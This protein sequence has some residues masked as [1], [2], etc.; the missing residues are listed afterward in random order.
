ME[1][2]LRNRLTLGP[3]L[4]AAVIGILFLDHY[5]E[6]WTTS[7]QLPNGLRG[8][9][10]TVMLML[11]VPLAVRELAI[12]FAAKHAK[13]YRVITSFGCGLLLLHAFLMQFPF[14]E[15]YSTPSLALIIVGGMLT[16]AYQRALLKKSEDA[17]VVM[18]GTV[19]ATLYLGGLCWF[20]IALRVLTEDTIFGSKF[21]GST[22]HVVMILIV[23]KFTDIGAYFTG[24]AL[25]KHKLIPWL[26]P[27][28]T[29]EGLFGGLVLAGIAGAACAPFIVHLGPT[30]GAIFG[31]LIGGVG[32]LGDLLESMMKRDA[33]VKDSGKL[34]PGFGGVMDVIDSPLLAAPFAYVLFALFTR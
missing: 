31:V 17:I 7:T 2:S 29:W 24:R 6:R 1:S 12:L 15:K 14:F 20:L 33:A 9:G 4:G 10:I 22:A 3:I 26:S 16:A 30:V 19:L 13:P 11:I 5:I 21:V 18:A 34:L 32:Q 27:G 28:K 8:V 25:G 23:V